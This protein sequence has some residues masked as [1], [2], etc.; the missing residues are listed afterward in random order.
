MRQLLGVVLFSVACAPPNFTGHDVDRFEVPAALFL[1]FQGASDDTLWFAGAT[2]GRFQAGNWTLLP[3]RHDIVL[4]AEV[5]AVSQD[6]AFAVGEADRVVRIRGVVAERLAVPNFVG[7]SAWANAADDVWIGGQ[8]STSLPDSNEILRWDG[9][10]LTRVAAPDPGFS[11]LSAG[12]SSRGEAF[13][14]ARSGGLFPIPSSDT[15]RRL[16]RC[17]VSGCSQVA[18]GPQQHL[19][20]LWAAANGEIWTIGD[21]RGV[22]RHHGGGWSLYPIDFEPLDISGNGDRVFVAARAGDGDYV[23]LQW[24]GSGWETFDRV[25]G[26]VAD[27]IWVGPSGYP[28]LFGANDLLL[29]RYR[30]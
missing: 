25:R 1:S 28:W 27:R 13:F 23:I 8:S 5:A 16:Y 29:V 20:K 14:V 10:R 2:L 24:T 17:Q 11:Y 26:L 3:D 15:E 18:E 19:G 22:A 12:G 9:A 6:E 30:S 4:N 7:A 21:A